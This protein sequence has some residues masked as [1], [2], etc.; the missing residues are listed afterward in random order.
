MFIRK[1]L[2]PV[3]LFVSLIAFG[4]A[5]AGPWPTKSGIAASA[6]DATAAGNNPAAITRF[7]EF[8]IQAGVLGLLGKRS[9][10]GV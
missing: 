4:T 1:Y 5:S 2:S 8:A 7:D 9:P 3:L 6:Q 10:Q